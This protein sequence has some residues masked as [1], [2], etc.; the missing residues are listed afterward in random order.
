MPRQQPMN[1]DVERV[2]LFQITYRATVRR[3]L[4][5]TAL[6]PFLLD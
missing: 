2:L 3:A 1:T 5:E 4:D 6:L